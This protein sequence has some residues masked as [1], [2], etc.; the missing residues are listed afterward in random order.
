M[1]IKQFL[2]DKVYLIITTAIVLMAITSFLYF[3]KISPSVIFMVALSVF[4]VFFSVMSVEFYRRYTYYN[5]ILDMTQVMEEKY[6]VFDLI[7]NRHFLDAAVMQEII[8]LG[9]YSMNKKVNL[10]QSS[11]EEY[12]NYI[13]LWVHEIKTPLAA[14]KLMDANNNL[15]NA[16]EELE[17]IS[18][19]IDQALYYARSSAVYK[20]YLIEEV[21]LKLSVMKTIKQLSNSFIKKDINVNVELEANNVYSDSKWLEFII[22]QILINA[23]QY[24]E[25][26]GEITI[27]SR[28][29]DQAIIL[30]VVDNGIG[31]KPEDLPRV[32]EQGFTGTSGRV[33]NQA[34]GMG[35]YLV[36]KLSDSL[37]INVSVSS[38]E[39]TIVALRIPKTNSH[40]KY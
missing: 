32:F 23:V 35:L 29:V 16:T 8:R 4:V 17:R 21:D 36:K 12:Q 9:N 24:S 3:I 11:Q 13:E 39:Q 2:K 37:Y 31:I 38:K 40:F 33:Y 5:E 26:H 30:E 6:L 22:K 15:S 27:R 7:E 28:N 18:Y 19:Y 20:D 1:T 25:E 34:T 10:Y 14:L